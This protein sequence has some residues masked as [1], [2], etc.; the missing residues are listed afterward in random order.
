[1]FSS[2][3]I[4]KRQKNFPWTCIGGNPSTHSFQDMFLFSFFYSF[5]YLIKELKSIKPMSAVG[6]YAIRCHVS[7]YRLKQRNF[8]I[9]CD[10]SNTVQNRHLNQLRDTGRYYLAKSSELFRRHPCLHNRHGVIF[11]INSCHNKQGTML[12]I[13]SERCIG[14][15]K[16]WKH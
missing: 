6:Q 7:S 2:I 15:N 8:L 1:M 5:P 12:E 4:E 10:D 11:A 16:L 14:G 13:S 9:R 3:K